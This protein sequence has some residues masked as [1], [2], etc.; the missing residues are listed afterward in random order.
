MGKII[1]NFITLN[2]IGKKFIFYVVLI[3]L[4]M[5]L[6]FK[7]F[8]VT[9]EYNKGYNELKSKSATMV[10]LASISMEDP[11]WNYNTQGVQISAD[12]L[13]KDKEIYYVNVLD[14]K[15]HELFK[16]ESTDTVY[17]K[18]S[19]F[20]VQKEI[21]KK[22]TKIG[23]VKLGFTNYYVNSEIRS[24]VISSMVEIV[25]MVVILVIVIT[26]VSR[27][28]T[29]PIEE[30][31]TILK[32]IS[33]GEGDLT[34][35]I[36]IKTK[37][38]VSKM[39]GYFNVFIEKMQQIIRQAKES[40]LNVNNFAKDLTDTLRRNT[41]S[42]VNISSTV[43]QTDQSAK[44]VNNSVQQTSATLEET[45]AGTSRISNDAQNIVATV[46]NIEEMIIKGEKSSENATEQIEV[47][48]NQAKVLSAISSDLKDAVSKISEIIDTIKSISEQTNLLAL[49]AA[50]ESARAG[51]SG[52]GFAVVA[53]EIRKLAEM[54]KESAKSIGDL[55]KEVT[56]KTM[57]T[58]D[59]VNEVSDR[60]VSGREKVMAVYSQFIE[61]STNMKEILAA[62]ENT[63]ASIQEQSASNQEITAVVDAIAH[64]TYEMQDNM[65]KVF[66]E[67]KDQTSEI[68]ILNDAAEKLLSDSQ[69][70]KTL[71]DK[72]KI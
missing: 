47:I 22:G 50:I 48:N 5:L 29:K 43:E 13:F 35:R 61:I 19:T 54:S 42:M 60:I 20:T 18:G 68:G 45:A 32:D 52:R 49:N 37:D 25:L 11:V 40:A 62:V 23:T 70:L 21:I 65:S 9:I 59:S 30:M 17:K 1:S 2:T 64:T 44:D 34:Q 7:I 24:K 66:N 14:D 72:F 38:E 10:N 31:I 6:G 71:L 69:E 36:E 33:E 55:L 57:V 8:E 63:S 3:N 12:A 39:A 51:E 16:K 4:V 58:F 27:V 15:G 28:V 67:I 41:Q 46:N 26:F 56:D 53:E